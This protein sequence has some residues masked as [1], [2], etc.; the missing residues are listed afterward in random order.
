MIQLFHY[1][2]VDHGLV[3]IE[4]D[5]WVTKPNPQQM[6]NGMPLTWFT[7][8][9]KPDAKALGLTA[10]MLRCDRTAVRLRALEGEYIFRWNDVRHVMPQENARRLEGARGTRPGLWWI[11]TEPV[12]VELA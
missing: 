5:G 8:L 2:C 4:A 6:L 1:T 11:A 7:P 3:G 10:L 9:M 12:K